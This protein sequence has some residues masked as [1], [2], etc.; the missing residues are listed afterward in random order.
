MTDTQN[1]IA[2]DN[3]PEAWGETLFALAEEAGRD[4]ASRDSSTVL[5]EILHDLSKVLGAYVARLEDIPRTVSAP[6]SDDLDI[7]RDMSP[8]RVAAPTSSVS[9]APIK[10]AGVSSRIADMQAALAGLDERLTRAFDLPGWIRDTLDSHHERIAALEAVIPGMLDKIAYL[11]SNANLVNVAIGNE[12]VAD[13][14]PIDPNDYAPE[15]WGSI[16]RARQALR[17]RVNRE[18]NSRAAVRQLVLQAVVDLASVQ[19][20]SDDDEMQLKQM[21]VRA[22]R[23]GELDVVRD[24]KLDEIA[25]LDDLEKARSYETGVGWP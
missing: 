20:R 21:Q 19:D 8:E 16:E 7:A 13:K 23:L 22:E 24:V 4:A 18:Y 1:A 15:T 17:N 2:V 12:F 5:S 11:E 9:A 6:S 10:G 3:T 14:T 25:N